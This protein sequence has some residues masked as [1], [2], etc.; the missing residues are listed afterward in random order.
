MSHTREI[1][2]VECFGKETKGSR[3]LETYAL[4]LGMG[5]VAIRRFEQCSSKFLLVSIEGY[6][7]MIPLGSSL[8]AARDK[9]KRIGPR[10]TPESYGPE[11]IDSAVAELYNLQE[12]LEVELTEEEETEAQEIVFSQLLHLRLETETEPYPTE[13]FIVDGKKVGH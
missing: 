1:Q 2:D 11:A 12:R 4:S 8:N 9:L 7:P 13:P 6:N 3:K 5:D 10:F